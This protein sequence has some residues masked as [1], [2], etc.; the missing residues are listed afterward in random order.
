MRFKIEKMGTNVEGIHITG[1][2]R[3]LE[4]ESFR[5]VFPYATVDVTRA[6]EGAGCDYW[7]HVYVNNS[8]HGGFSGSLDEGEFS[9]EGAVLDAR[10]DQTDKHAAESNLGDFGRPELYHVA[11][12]IGD[13]KK[14]DRQ[15]E[16]SERT[17]PGKVRQ[18][19]SRP[20]AART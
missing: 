13:A 19:R 2:P 7:V 3:N 9:A 17:T 14:G 18:A 12:R 10:L 11:V 20:R 15:D 4:P 1:N 5:I 8:R 16:T 6:T